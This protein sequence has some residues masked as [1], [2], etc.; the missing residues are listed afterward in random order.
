MG[1]RHS[2]GKNP[3]SE[4]ELE[5]TVKHDHSSF[6]VGRLLHRTFAHMSFSRTDAGSVRFPVV[7]LLVV[8]AYKV[9]A[10]VVTVRRA[11]DDMDVIFVRLFVLAERNAPL[12]VELDDDDRA[13][14]TIVKHA[15]VVHAAHPA[16]VGIP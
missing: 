12:M 13:L 9:F 2:A 3:E 8:L 10:V 6:P 11:H 15:V 5:V 16:K 14:D 7:A 1:Q 4:K